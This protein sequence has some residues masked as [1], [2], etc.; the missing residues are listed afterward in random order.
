MPRSRKDLLRFVIL[1]PRPRELLI[2]NLTHSFLHQPE[3]DVPADAPDQDR[4]DQAQRTIKLQQRRIP[5]HV[6]QNWNKER[7]QESRIEEH[8]D[9]DWVRSF[10]AP[11][12]AG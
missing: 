7:T 9:A 4:L 1:D 3:D 11:E 2:A 12:C 5:E 6:Q 8:A 10:D